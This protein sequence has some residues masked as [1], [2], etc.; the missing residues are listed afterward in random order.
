MST[1]YMLIYECFVFEG[2]RRILLQVLYQS[3]DSC[4]SNGSFQSSGWEDCQGVY[5]E[6][7]QTGSLQ[8]LTLERNNTT[9]SPPTIIDVC[10]NMRNVQL[11]NFVS[12]IRFIVCLS[13]Q[14]VCKTCS[15]SLVL[16][17]SCS[18]A[19][20]LL[21]STVSCEVRWRETPG[22]K[23]SVHPSKC[24]SPKSPKPLFLNFASALLTSSL[25]GL[26][27]GERNCPARS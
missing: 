4:H 26:F 22:P 16:L 7:G 20:G 14:F 6:S 2:S 9:M 11:N 8:I 10:R 27:V 23:L 21:V 1:T 15:L 18:V 3:P 13:L 19:T 25:A 5:S 24:G 12:N 17:S